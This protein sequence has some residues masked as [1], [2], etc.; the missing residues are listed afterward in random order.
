MP[1]RGSCLPMPCRVAEKGWDSMSFRSIGNPYCSPNILAKRPRSCHFQQRARLRFKLFLKR[2]WILL[3]CAVIVAAML[4]LGWVSSNRPFVSQVIAPSVVAIV[5]ANYFRCFWVI[6]KR[7]ALGAV[8]WSYHWELAAS[9]VAIG[10]QTGSLYPCMC[11]SLTGELMLKN[12][13]EFAA[14]FGSPIV[15]AM[16]FVL[17]RRTMVACALATLFVVTLWQLQPAYANWIHS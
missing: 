8:D 13:F 15:V 10:F 17:A 7:R 4:E 5:A 11:A 14:L 2:R 6:T 9:F 3:A 12:Y 16:I 1:V